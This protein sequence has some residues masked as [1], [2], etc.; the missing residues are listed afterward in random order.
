MRK[1]I[2][3]LNACGR[4][5]LLTL[6]LLTTSILHPGWISCSQQVDEV[7]NSR[8]RIALAN[9]TPSLDALGN[10]YRIGPEDVLDIRVF[11]RPQLSRDAVR[12]DGRGMITMPLIEEIQAACKTEKELA[13]E[14]ATRY[15]EYQ[16]NPQVDVF[17]KEYKSKPVAVIGAV[18][19]PGQFQLQRRVRLLELLAFA[20]GPHDRAGRVVQVIHTMTRSICE[21]PSPSATD[22]DSAEAL[23]DAAVEQY[24]LN[25]MRQ[26]GTQSNPFAQ[27]GD[28]VTV[29]EAAQAYVVGNVLRPT[30]IPL[31]ELVTISQAIAMAGGTMP[32]TKTDKVRIIRR[33]PGSVLKSE[34]YVDLKAI[35]KQRAD[36]IALQANDIVDV[37][38]SGGKRF[39]RSLLSTVAPTVGQLPV[40]VIP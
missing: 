8:P 20:G 18:N 33:M 7:S 2:V 4:L 15:L 29:L 11:N 1:S 26:G 39:L 28:I 24:D 27:P 12:V 23:D 9:T 10:S 31:K 5:V 34:I 36:D 6:C 13:N 3:A 35:E 17:I 22:T 21:P 25:E 19:S 16:R 38:T 30:A 32:D 40:R 14:I 37:P